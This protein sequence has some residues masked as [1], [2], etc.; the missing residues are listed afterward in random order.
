MIVEKYAPESGG[1]KYA[2][3]SGPSARESCRVSY[4]PGSGQKL[5]K[6]EEMAETDCRRCRN[7][8]PRRNPV[9]QWA[10]ALEGLTRR[11]TPNRGDDRRL[12]SSSQSIF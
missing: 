8:K 4:A 9:P 11:W 5:G 1:E 7:G 2:R 12:S 10:D 3:V 6:N